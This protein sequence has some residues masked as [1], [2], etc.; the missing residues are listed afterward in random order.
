MRGRFILLAPFALALLFLA[1]PLNGNLPL[2]DSFFFTM[3]DTENTAH[4]SLLIPQFSPTPLPKSSG[5]VEIGA[6]PSPSE[7]VSPAPTPTMDASPTPDVPPSL[8]FSPSPSN[9]AS[10]APTPSI[11][12]SS[13]IDIYPS[14]TYSPSPISSP[15]PSPIFSPTPTVEPTPIFSPTPSFSPTPIF[16][17]S[18]SISPSP[19]FSPTP[20]PAPT[21]IISPSPSIISTPSPTIEPVISPIP[22]IEPSISP[23]PSLE[24]SIIPSPSTSENQTDPKNSINQTDNFNQS[25]NET[26]SD[27]TISNQSH[28]L[29]VLEISE[30]VEGLAFLKNKF[31]SNS[32]ITFKSL[33]KRLVEINGTNETRFDL[34]ISVKSGKLK[35]GNNLQKEKINPLDASD[36][37]I[38]GEPAPLDDD[39]EESSI[40]ITG[41]KD[42]AS[43]LNI[44]TEAPAR[45]IDLV[46]TENSNTVA[47]LTTDFIGFDDLAFDEAQIT[48]SSYSKTERILVC[49]S[50]DALANSCSNWQISEMP[51][52]ENAD[53]IT[54]STTHFSGYAGANITVLNVQSFPQVQGSWIVKF[55]TSGVAPLTISPTDGTTFGGDLAFQSLRCGETPLFPEINESS[56]HL[57][58]YSC[59]QEG[60]EDSRVLTEGAHHL[61]FRFGEAVAFADNAASQLIW[62]LQNK[63]SDLGGSYLT[64]NLSSIAANFDIY[65]TTFPDVDYAS[66]GCTPFSWFTPTFN[67]TA[68]NEVEYVNGT[69]TTS[70]RADTG[71]IGSTRSQVFFVRYYKFNSTGQH[72]IATSATYGRNCTSASPPFT[73]A[74][75][76]SIPF[77]GNS[78]LEPGGRIGVQMCVRADNTA[79]CSVATAFWNRS[80][81]YVRFYN[82]TISYCG[83][84]TSSFT[85]NY[86][87]PNAQGTCYEVKANNLVLDCKGNSI[88]GDGT[89]IGV[90]V[91]GYSNFTIKN[92]NISNFDYAVLVNR[93]NSFTLLNSTIS[94]STS[95]LR[96]DSSNFT[97]VTSTKFLAITLNQIYA[98]AAKNLSVWNGFFSSCTS[99]NACINVDYSGNLSLLHSIFVN[100]AYGLSLQGS[101]SSYLLNDT[102]SGTASNYGVDISTSNNATMINSTI[103][104]FTYGIWSNSIGLALTNLTISNTT[105]AAVTLL[106]SNSN[107]SRLS[108]LG[109]ANG[110]GIY[111][112]S[113][114]LNISDSRINNFSTGINLV[115]GLGLILSNVSISNS[116][117][118]I[119]I[120]AASLIG[121]IN[122]ARLS[123]SGSGTGIMFS[124]ASN[125]FSIQN[126]SIN[127]FSTG[128]SIASNYE[129]LLNLSISNSTT[130]ISLNGATDARI[131]DS[132]LTGRH[133]GTGIVSQ[134]SPYASIRNLSISN[135]G[136]GLTTYGSDYLSFFNNSVFNNTGDA[137]SIS[138]GYYCNITSNHLYRNQ[139]GASLD[140]SFGY[141]LSFLRM[142]SNLVEENTDVGARLQI[143]GGGAW[144]TYN[145]IENNTFRNNTNQNLDIFSSDS[146]YTLQ[147]YDNNFTS[148][149]FYGSPNGADIQL[150]RSRNFIFLNNTFNRSKLVFVDVAG[151]ISNLTLMNYIR[152]NVTDSNLF[153]IYGVSVNITNSTLQATNHAGLLTDA[154]GLTE[155][156]VVTE[157]IGNDSENITMQYYNFTAISG[158][159]MNSTLGLVNSS[160]QIHLVMPITGACGYLTSN[161]TLDSDISAPGSCFSVEAHNITL[162]CNGKRIVGSGSENGIILNNFDN[163]TLMN[164]VIMNFSYGLSS[165][166]TFN[167]SVINSSFIANSDGIYLNAFGSSVTYVNISLSKFINNTDSGLVLAKGGQ[168]HQ[169]HSVQHSVFENNTLANILLSSFTYPEGSFGTNWT[170]NVLASSPGGYDID[171]QGWQNNYFINTTFNR[172]RIRFGAG[173][174]SNLT[175]QNYIRANVTDINFNLVNGAQVNI[176]NRTAGATN[177]TLLST[178]SSG[179]T[180]YQTITEFIGNST[181]NTT[182]AYYNI[183]GSKSG[184][185]NATLSIVNTSN[186]VWLVVPG[187]FACGSLS[188]SA[189]LGSDVSAG[190][191]CFSITG[192]N[193]VLDC[194][195]YT[196]T[197]SY[198]ANS[199][200]I[201]ASGRT[202]VTIKNCTI[203]KFQ[204]GILIDRTN[205]ATLILNTLVNNS[206]SGIN[207]TKGDFAIVGNNTF[208]ANN[209]YS[210]FVNSSWYSTVSQ[211][212]IIN[213]SGHPGWT[214][215]SGRNAT[216]IF[217]MNFSNGQVRN[218][219][220]SRILGGNADTGGTAG[221]GGWGFGITLINA[222][223]N[224]L[225]QNNI[226]AITGGIARVGQVATTDNG[227]RGGGAVGIY[228]HNSYNNTLANVTIFNISGGLGAAGSN[229][230]LA[231]GGNGSTGGS[232]FGILIINSTLLKITVANLS[233]LIAADGGDGGASAG[234]AGFGAVGGSAYGIFSQNSSLLATNSLNISGVVA[235]KGG[236]GQSGPSPSSAGAGGDSFGI[237]LLGSFNNTHSNGSVFNVTAGIGG[238]GNNGAGANKGGNGSYGGA[239]SGIRIINSTLVRFNSV[240]GT[241]ILAGNGGTGGTSGTSQPGNGGAGGNASFV[242]ISSSL[243]VT[244]FYSN[245]TNSTG[246]LN[247]S[248]GGSSADHGALGSGYGIE[249]LNSN[250]TLVNGSSILNVTASSLG[251]SALIQ[252]LRLSGSSFNNISDTNI[253]YNP[254]GGNSYSSLFLDRGSRENIFQNLSFSSRNISFGTGN[255]SLF[256]KWNVL[257][258]VTTESGS[259]G[260]NNAYVSIT[261]ALSSTPL[262]QD[263]TNAQGY[264]PM[265]LLTEF[266]GNATINATYIPYNFTATRSGYPS[267]T[268]FVGITSY[269]L[270]LL[271]LNSPPSIVLGSPA[272]NSWNRSTTVIFNYTPIDGS[273]FSNCSLWT[274]NSGTFGISAGNASAIVNNSPN[275]IDFTFT[276]GDGGYI[277]NV[278]CF[279]NSNPS[280][281]SF[282]SANRTIKIDTL[283][284][285]QVKTVAPT[286]ANNSNTYVNWIFINYTFSETNP[287]SCY[288]QYYNGSESN[289]SATMVGNHNCYLNLTGQP[290]GTWNYSIFVNDSAG[291]LGSNLSFWVNLDSNPPRN[292]TTIS[293]TLAN[294]SYT[295]RNWVF[296]NASFVEAYPNVCLLQFNNGSNFNYTMTRTGTNCYYNLTG[297]P[298]GYWNYS[299]IVNDTVNNVG[300]N[301]TFFVNVDTLPPNNLQQAFPT[302]ANNSFLNR[303]WAFLNFTFNET[304]FNSCWIYWTNSSNYNLT[305][306]R[307]GNSCY[308]NVTGQ[309][310]G[311]WNYS[312]WINDSAGNAEF[313]GTFF[314]N[315]DSSPP[316]SLRFVNPTPANNSRLYYNWAFINASFTEGNF[317]TCLLRWGNGTFVNLTMNE[318][319][320]GNCYLNV[321]GN[322]LGTA[323]YTI[324]V[325]DS[326][327]N[328]AQNGTFYIQFWANTSIN[329]FQYPQS[330][331]RYGRANITAIFSRNDLQNLTLSTSAA[332]FNSGNGTNITINDFNISMAYRDEPANTSYFNSS[333]YERTIDAGYANAHWLL[334]WNETIPANSTLIVQSSTSQDN[335][336]FTQFTNFS[337]SSGSIANNTP[338][339]YLK[340][341]LLFYSNGS[342][343]AF[344]NEINATALFGINGGATINLTNTASGNALT[345]SCNT[346]NGNCSGA[347]AFPLELPGGNY[348]INITASNSSAYYEAASLIYR[349]Y[350]EEAIT[351]GVVW[352]PEKQLSL[353]P[354]GT[355]FLINVTLNNTGN[356]SM[357]NPFIYNTGLDTGGTSTLYYSSCG[358]SL[359][360]NASCFSTWNETV[361][362]GLDT[363]DY[364]ARW[365]ANWTNNNQTVSL[366]SV[367]SSTI[368][369]LGSP[370]LTSSKSLINVTDGESQSNVTLI[371]LRNEGNVD[372]YNVTA[373]FLPDNM[374][375]S[376]ITMTLTPTSP[377]ITPGF[378]KTLN[379]TITVPAPYAPGTYTGKINV[380]ADY[381]SAGTT[382]VSLEI[383][384]SVFVNPVLNATP[385]NITANT[386]LSSNQTLL[387]NVSNPGNA[388]ITNVSV[389]LTDSNIPAGWVFFNSTDAAWDAVTNSFTRV[390]EGTTPVLQV[391]ISVLDFLANVF[392]GL[393][394]ITTNEGLTSYVNLTIIVNPELTA[395]DLIY[396]QT[397]HTLT[398][399]TSF[400]LNSTGNIKLVDVN[401]AYIAG[402]LNSGWISLS[403]ANV[404]NITEG[405]LQA[406]GLNVSVPA[407]TLPGN[408][409]GFL[410]ISAYNANKTINLTV[411]VPLDTSWNFTPTANQTSS[412]MLNRQGVIAAI[413]L[414]NLGNIDLLFAI[415]YQNLPDYAA[416]VGGCFTL[417]YNSTHN[418]TSFWVNRTSNRTFVVF[419][420]FSGA[421]NNSPG[422][423]KQITIINASASPVS[424]VSYGFFNITNA[425]PHFIYNGTSAKGVLQGHVGFNESI[426]LSVTG[427]D[428]EIYGLNVSS[429]IYNI[430][431]PDG[432]NDTLQAANASLDPYVA[433][434]DDCSDAQNLTLDY[435]NT[436][437]SGT[438][439]VTLQVKDRTGQQNMTSFTF[440]VITTTSLNLTGNNTNVTGVQR[441]SNSVLLL[442][443]SINN[444]GLVNAYS[445][446]LSGMFTKIANATDTLAN[447]SFTPIATIPYINGSARN[448][449]TFNITI[450][451]R[452]LGLYY[453]TPN[454]TWTQ[455][456]G[457]IAV[458]WGPNISIEALPNPDFNL[459]AS[460][461][462][463]AMQHGTN[464]TEWLT[465]T[466]VGN[467]NITNYNVTFATSFTNFSVSFNHTSGN[468]TIDENA[469][470]SM[471]ISAYYAAI[472]GLRNF[473]I[474]VTA[475]GIS[476]TFSANLTIPYNNTWIVST[477]AYSINGIASDSAVDS[478]VTATHAGTGDAFLNYSIS[479]TGNMTSFSTLLNLTKALNAT[480]SFSPSISYIVP[481]LNAQYVGVLNLTERN[482]SLTRLV[483]ITFNSYTVEVHVHSIS[484]PG[485]VLAGD[486]INVTARLVFAGQN[487]TAN[488]SW[489]VFLDSTSCPIFENSTDGNYTL[490]NCTAPVATDARFH[491]ISTRINFTNGQVYLVK[492]ITNASAVFYRDITAPVFIFEQ[493]NDTEAGHTLAIVLNATDNFQVANATGQLTFPNSTSLNISLPFNSTLQLFRNTFNFTDLGVYGLSYLVND[494][495][496]NYN[497]SYNGSFEIYLVRNFN[498]SIINLEGRPIMVNFTVENSTDG[499]LETFST[500]ASGYYG[501]S[502]RA[503]WYSLN[504]NF[505]FYNVTVT[506]ADFNTLNQSF[507]SMDNFSGSDISSQILGAKAGFAVITEL[508]SNGTIY[509]DYTPLL[510]SISDESVLRIYQ[511]LN[512]T[513]A[514]RSCLSAWTHLNNSGL[515]LI[516]NRIS[517]NF[518]IFSNSTA[519][520]ALVQYTV[521]TPTP[522]TIVIPPFVGGNTGG[523]GGGGPYVP[524]ATPTPKPKDQDNIA[525]Q[526]EELKKL[527]QQQNKTE[528]PPNGVETGIQT[529]SFELLPG[530][531]AQIP[532]HLKNTL[533]F[534]SRINGTVTNSVIRFISLSQDSILLHKNHETDL[535]VT[536]T[537]PSDAKA[538][539]FFGELVLSN[540]VGKIKIPITV[541]VLD[542]KEERA[543]DLKLQPLVDTIDPG[544]T[545][546]LEVNVYNLGTPRNI[547]GSLAL[548]LVDPVTD[549]VLGKSEPQ[550]FLFQTAHNGI[551]PIKIPSDARNGRYVVRGVLL[552]SS[553]GAAAKEVTSITYVRVQASIWSARLFGTLAFWQLIPI[554]LILLASI[555]TY[556][557]E[558]DA[559]QRKRRY[560]AKVDFTK[561]PEAGSRAGF[562]GLI[563]ETKVRAFASLDKLQTHT[564]I[565]GATGS[566]KT[567]AAQVLV[568]EAL[569][570]NTAVMVFDPTAQWT[571]FLR[572][573]K[574]RD[575]FSSYGKF[576]MNSDE[577]RAFKGNIY[578]VR[579]PNLP[580]DVKKFMK[581]GEITVFVM[582]KLSFADHETFIANTVRQV[583]AAG[584]PESPQLKLLLV[585]DE[586]HRLLTKFGGRGEGFVQIERGAREFRKW[587]VGMVLISQVLSDFV[588][589]IKANIGT[590]I[591]LRTKYE[592][593]LERLKMKFGEDAARS[594]VKESIGSGMVQNSEYN[595][596]QPYFVTFRPLLHNVVRLSD[597]ELSQYEAYNGKVEKIELEMEKLRTAGEDVL[598][599]ELEV[600]LARDKVKKGAFNIVEIY[601]ESLEQKIESMK[602]KAASKGKKDDSSPVLLDLAFKEPVAQEPQAEDKP[603]QPADNEKKDIA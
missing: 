340:Y 120:S 104:N 415:D 508:P 359:A 362:S 6:S 12:A 62:Y 548:E 454:V 130:A 40:E 90:N 222:T 110:T 464:Q 533:N 203:T 107:F 449:T 100:S 577:A 542:R 394:R 404:G 63:T 162:D 468:L 79:G 436:N 269:Q 476:K 220:I 15:S 258:R 563:A 121:L 534:S 496:G 319:G 540:E 338:A 284:P 421:S 209:N 561:L 296:V 507:I 47:V 238:A 544:E 371:T 86:N 590:E 249:I 263:Y 308:L 233:T 491:N 174:N 59:I 152:A 231:D 412:F 579:D 450:G 29:T 402:T 379:A 457:S 219:N 44:Q 21:P 440:S 502:L 77:S 2:L 287:Q 361:P 139:I 261:S 493:S 247:G 327:G 348:T 339:R 1:I 299:I 549:T 199:I 311:F 547:A 488:T 494:T 38:L 553:E 334:S 405:T 138:G 94:A 173:S 537:I 10:P 447:W 598:D 376:W 525:A 559:A 187:V 229:G 255:N 306:T 446:N 566:G 270:V 438:Y 315:F 510:P 574:N 32:K 177:F 413:T 497:G 592:G 518:S 69:Y 416:C 324:F 227:G 443:V 165:T 538:G 424:A 153:G 49:D 297:Q 14:P 335:V 27:L 596:G 43:F 75:T 427:V 458:A 253:H 567:V 144:V 564:L 367:Y 588:G 128:I 463:L 391:I 479:L 441:S 602:K 601:L 426:T 34:S 425:F 490:L 117:I 191:T 200:G 414:F 322:Q 514:L 410:N 276:G 210:I 108:L 298:E 215:A 55:T 175:I 328:L 432:A 97:N 392:T 81:T 157:F 353:P 214:S 418:P 26:Q 137:L 513:Y 585:Y 57:G 381:P 158:A 202:N 80:D 188:S 444:T 395:P 168:Y 7:T 570:K 246:G 593:D 159:A 527:L 163:F 569:L 373:L 167:L 277:W 28:N 134:N 515:N 437:V 474:N 271:P 74:E 149:V 460:N 385:Q 388:P 5:F 355:W 313:N 42:I 303:S 495:T 213:Q 95:G 370:S 501:V 160:G 528:Q 241:L 235:G 360:P 201:N 84:L 524:P 572:A 190:G 290:D 409:T 364:Y 85:Q 264:I 442:N 68:R 354:G 8:A 262:Y 260:I 545:L 207:I 302:P 71:G 257:V 25:E 31:K 575:M 93:S 482:S 503:K 304:N 239:A 197:G 140:Q 582:N 380:T 124:G 147:F 273:G 455:P 595:N 554:L 584:L 89:G 516:S 16:S 259:A 471:N 113:A 51:F 475:G 54:F 61:E 478:T 305:M 399:V 433:C 195:G 22:S 265:Q 500:N 143:T 347:F 228:F 310:D 248:R 135:F 406:I 330:Y 400:Q 216:G 481:D 557:R 64:L 45:K 487:T 345:K 365:Q 274:N 96:I 46:K 150:T 408:Y 312:F 336:T 369:I 467:D 192:N 245:F 430:S 358:S 223:N 428:D 242:Q 477:N 3:N 576:G 314:L 19:E 142:V 217:L 326:A 603:K 23:S 18:P 341:R 4:D 294:G 99:S 573:Q 530:E 82:E 465:I 321:T 431:R 523:G 148:N 589:E 131:Y 67:G 154:Q 182:L 170:S 132:N 349:F 378:T 106:G 509:V 445:V 164:C 250:S 423:A 283:P 236:T 286:L 252:P 546:R 234:Q 133:A 407:G 581:P 320:N 535:T 480:Q 166:G 560:I 377:K 266:Y 403:T 52:T 448:L 196:I 136:T 512:Y 251:A 17:P 363:G 129:T 268:Q 194:R 141:D 244:I 103:N 386:S 254:V 180:Q 186:T 289:Y 366:S 556:Y 470:V 344:I 109:K 384:I 571:G 594:I 337:N 473:T 543:V 204:T 390:I 70:Y 552:Y 316:S 368:T 398:N 53:S 599:L 485:Q 578:I 531:S 459:T 307:N 484:A 372:L 521:P 179:L 146:G 300:V 35:K 116:S 60:I 325:N 417:N 65:N 66:I 453:F 83:N 76:T 101:D 281:S 350:F 211:N 119:N 439:Y 517:A 156:R 58:A 278:Q 420:G 78:I 155:Y 205:N 92:C 112:A 291:N 411:N 11:D 435:N 451:E 145:T 393:I 462:S 422:Y 198:A 288:V 551:Y 587:G 171:M 151:V 88:I 13:A 519:A 111:S 225:V 401:I 568:E 226:S 293:P 498:G 511:C 127:N 539:N 550:T 586:V 20:S 114:N 256:M 591:Q 282:A 218:N 181:A 33:K 193:V 333:I 520:F 600:N 122:D 230:V 123:G 397:A 489:S 357:L 352:A 375:G 332:D 499:N 118:A 382:A 212:Y 161:A 565:A 506:N 292:I 37:P 169:Y 383:N 541:R 387:V 237:Y 30:D 206:N 98:T 505:I 279:D 351:A 486:P 356:A 115:G 318:D 48:L 317:D 343:S 41:L 532:V 285:T 73:R 105:L 483:N 456:N 295:N 429:A 172:S 396:L 176:T 342:V 224:N 419:K 272:D 472:S 24:P 184:I 243:N 50:Y 536:G 529:L 301:G 126:S 504:L 189:S 555:A 492:N 580:I 280:A 9:Y 36:G 562:V 267:A 461:R 374:P 522:T 208:A 221:S 466:P 434:G 125:N 389:T 87:I 469:N 331:D 240:N 323:N 185:V 91:S 452:S 526:I 39:F 558:Y 183:S 309:T 72:L 583:F 56:V 275:N 346:L 597:T 102:F 178:D 232:S 329:Y